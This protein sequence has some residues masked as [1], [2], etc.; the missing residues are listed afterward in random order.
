MNW[1]ASKAEVVLEPETVYE[2]TDLPLQ[3]SKRGWSP[4]RVRQLRDPGIYREGHD[5]YLLYSVAGE[6]GIAIAKIT[7]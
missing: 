4:E 7:E 3:P 2:G 6:S 5:T 1:R